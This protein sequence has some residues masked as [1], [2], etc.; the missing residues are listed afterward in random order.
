[1]RHKAHGACSRRTS[2]FSDGVEREPLD[3]GC[4]LRV[5][6]TPGRSVVHERD[7]G[8]TGIAV[9][10]PQRFELISRPN[11]PGL[12]AVE[13]TTIGGPTPA[14]T[15]QDDPAGRGEQEERTRENQQPR[16]TSRI[17]DIFRR[18]IKP[19]ERERSLKPIAQA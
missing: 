5:G 17:A 13:I 12:D 19:L 16:P 10:F 4:A 14:A 1:M 15:V 7:A 8:R 3:H 11:R 9:L 18:S 6:L 2:R